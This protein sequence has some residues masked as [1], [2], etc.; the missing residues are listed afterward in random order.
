MEN[1]AWKPLSFA[2]LL[3]TVFSEKVEGLAQRHA[4]CF[5]AHACPWGESVDSLRVSSL[6]D[7]DNL[8]I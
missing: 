2:R 7:V 8:Y 6:T 5:A 3:I 4:S 1:G